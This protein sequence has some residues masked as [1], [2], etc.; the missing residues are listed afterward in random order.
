MSEQNTAGTADA[1]VAKAK[2]KRGDTIP[3]WQVVVA[4][5]EITNILPDK[6]KSP[7]SAL[8]AIESKKIENAIGLFRPL[9]VEA[10]VTAR[11]V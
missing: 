4:G 3:R 8:R 5:N 11:L 7:E 1:G 2:N 9:A 10:K 6:Y